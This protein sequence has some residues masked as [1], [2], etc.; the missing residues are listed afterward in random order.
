MA[1]TGQVFAFVPTCPPGTPESAPLTINLTMPTREIDSIRIRVP[2]G[3][4]GCVGWAL[5]AAG[6]QYIPTPPTSFAIDD[7]TVIDWALTELIDSGAW[8]AQ[9]WNIGQY[10]HSIYVY[11]TVH[12]PDAPPQQTSNLILPAHLL[13]SG[14]AAPVAAPLTLAP[15][16]LVAS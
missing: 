14:A 6:Q 4:S 10:P 7:N 5:A 11:F 16:Q 15:L 9:M 12:V 3:H 13:G 1:G 8:Q 2:P